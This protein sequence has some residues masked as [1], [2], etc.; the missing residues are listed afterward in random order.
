MLHLAEKKR[1][2]GRWEEIKNY[3]LKERAEERT[4]CSEKE[5]AEENKAP[6]EQ[7]WKESE[8]KG[9][10]G[11]NKPACSDE[12]QAGSGWARRNSGEV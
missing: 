8:G 3:E 6:K 2:K 5:Q 12:G 4:A 9:G 11:K 10:R 1:R 7:A